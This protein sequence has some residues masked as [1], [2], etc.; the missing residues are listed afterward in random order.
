M[1]DRV[2]NLKMK[3]LDDLLEHF[4]YERR[5]VE[6]THDAMTDC[7]LTAKVYMKIMKIPQKENSSLGFAH[8]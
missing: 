8:E 6:T 4:G 1:S 2:P 3:G 7:I 5:D